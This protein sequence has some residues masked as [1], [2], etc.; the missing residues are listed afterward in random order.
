MTK[1]IPEVTKLG[2]THHP[3]KFLTPFPLIIFQAETNEYC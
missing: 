2:L 3:L 1:N